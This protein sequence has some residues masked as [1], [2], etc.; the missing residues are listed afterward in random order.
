MIPVD[1]R[2]GVLRQTAVTAYLTSKQ[3]QPFVCAQGHRCV[4]NPGLSQVT[5]STK[6]TSQPKVTEP[7]LKPPAPEMTPD[8]CLWT[9]ASMSARITCL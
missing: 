5:S 2:R 4:L 6:Y 9:E 7:T 3:L 1:S 8:V